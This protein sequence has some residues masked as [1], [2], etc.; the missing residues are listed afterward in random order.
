MTTG[1]YANSD[2]TALY[3]FT[4]IP[5]YDHE[6]NIIA[7]TIYE[8]PV[9]GFAPAQKKDSYDLVNKY[10]PPVTNEDEPITVHKEI[11]VTTEDGTVPQRIFEFVL[12]ALDGAPMP[13]DAKD[14]IITGSIDG[15]GSVDLGLITF[16]APGKYTYT[17]TEAAEAAAGWTSDQ[18]VYTLVYKT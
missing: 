12:T 2:I 4:G 18:T 11:T 3:T 13:Q 5:K 16:T 9:E 15:P 1:N 14:G 8:T 10:V 6:G 17:L 7:Y